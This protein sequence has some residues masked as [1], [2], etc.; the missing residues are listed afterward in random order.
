VGYIYV[1]PIGAIE[2][3]ALQSL[4]AGLKL[5]F[6]NQCSILEN[7]DIPSRAFD[8]K[9]NQ[10]S[11]TEILKKIVDSAPNDTLKILG[12]T[13]VDLFIPVL[14]FVF[15]QAQLNGIA[16]I[17]SLHRL[18]QEYYGLPANDSLFMERAIKEAV[19]EIGH[20]F[21]MVHCPDNRCVMYFS[22]SVRNVDMKTDNFCNGCLKLLA[23]K[24]A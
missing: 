1:L 15:G 13:D 11:S 24:I 4:A 3:R 23:P 14:T 18:R 16:S 5:K 2:R 9:R 20:T 7:I 21:G 22:N 6:N 17:I 19:H 12:V 10:Y 8:S